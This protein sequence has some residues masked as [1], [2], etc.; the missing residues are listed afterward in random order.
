MSRATSDAVTTVST[1]SKL[2]DDALGIIF[3]FIGPAG[4]GNA[5]YVGPVNHEEL[6]EAQ[7]TLHRVALVSKRISTVATAL[8]ER[9][10]GACRPERCS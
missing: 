4:M 6:V 5:G 7:A 9:H 1:L 8:A 3:G 2:D 10:V